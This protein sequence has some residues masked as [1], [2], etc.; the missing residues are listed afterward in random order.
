MENF[1]RTTREGN[2][3]TLDPTQVAMIRAYIEKHKLGDIESSALMCCETIATRQ[4]LDGKEERILTIVILTPQ[5]LIWA[6]RILNE[7]P[8]VLF[9]RLDDIQVEDY[10]KTIGYHVIPAT[11]LR[12]WWP[13]T[14]SIDYNS[15]LIGLGSEP[16]AQKFR[17]LLKETLAKV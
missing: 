1:V 12:I 9:I 6:N 15:V 2:L 10:E 17:T 8:R 7:A 4:K 13:N 11:G 14:D 5:W 3:D 16:A